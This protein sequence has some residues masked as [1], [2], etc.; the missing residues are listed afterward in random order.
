MPR[1]GF[2][3]TIAAGER[4]LG[5]TFYYSPLKFFLILSSYLSPGL[6][7]GPL[8]SGFPPEVCV[9]LCSQTC[10]AYSLLCEMHNN[11]LVPSGTKTISNSDNPNSL[12][13]KITLYEDTGNIPGV[14]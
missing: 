1:V 2:E 4:L 13:T 9:H 8:P 12:R 6:R 11:V 10:L 5:P 14:K 3:P 7:S